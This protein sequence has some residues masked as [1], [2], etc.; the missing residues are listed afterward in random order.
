[1]FLV[2]S[3]LGLA[4]TIGFAQGAGGQAPAAPA[5]TGPLAP[6]KYK[7][8]QILKD[9]PADQLE[10]TMRFVSAATGFQCADCHVRE[11]DGNFSYDKDDKRTKATAREMMKIERA[12]NDQ[13]FSSRVQV[14]CMTCHRGANR[15]VS[16]PTLADP[17]T[18]DQLAAMAAA[19][20][21]AAGPG[22]QGGA[23]A[24]GAPAAPGPPAPGGGRG[25]LPPL[26][27]VTAK[28][29]AGMGGQAALDTLKTLVLSGTLTNRAG[30]NVAFTIEEKRPDAYRETVQAPPNSVVRA[31]DGHA[32]WQQVG[33]T[34][35]DLTG[36]VLQQARRLA[37]LGLPLDVAKRLDGLRVARGPQINGTAVI[38]LA[39]TSAPYQTETIFIDA[40]SGVMLRRTFV[41]R[42]ALGNLAEQ[43]DYSDYRDVAGVKIPFTIKRASWDAVDTLKIVDVKPNATIADSRFARAK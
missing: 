30:Q 3:G 7:N 5:P 35:T 16:Q 31:F 19:A 21:R 40:N 32:G 28:F 42:T 20:Q 2:L 22:P 1:L 29:V 24:P 38:G 39:G 8:I 34:T 6:E 26:D 27:E 12:V 25:A 33:T 4:G 37:D 17:F 14:T 15:P 18:P 11:A 41:T 23:G 43:V 10:L 13:F 9:V 36:L